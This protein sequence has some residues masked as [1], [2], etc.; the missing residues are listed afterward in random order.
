[1]SVKL[2]S[3]AIVTTIFLSLTC[4]Y[5]LIAGALAGLID[6]ALAGLIVGALV[7]FIDTFNG[8]PVGVFPGLHPQFALIKFATMEHTVF[9]MYPSAPTF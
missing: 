8:A 2:F 9:G 6:R 3:I 1:M 5:G 7:G 4:L